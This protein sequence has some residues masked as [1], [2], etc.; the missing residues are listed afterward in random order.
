MSKGMLCGIDLGG[1]KV[2][3]GLFDRGLHP[4]SSLRREIPP[5]IHADDLITLL[6]SLYESLAG[7]VETSVEAI[8]VG[9]PA[10]LTQGAGV[11]PAC[12]N[13]PGV[14][15]VPLASLLEERTGIRV[16][17]ENDANCFALGEYLRGVGKGAHCLVGLTL[18]T[19]IGM[20]AVIAG[21]IHRGWRNSAGEI[22][23]LPMPDGTILEDGLAGSDVVRSANA[24]TAREAAEHAR[25]GAS[26]AVRAWREF[27]ERLRWVIE[28]VGRVLDPDV[29]V[30]GGSISAAC[31]VWG[32]A[33][34]GTPWPVRISTA[35]EDSALLGAAYVAME[36][37]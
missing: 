29:F 36:M 5:G 35:P 30:L 9:V 31:D 12:A 25:G 13:L 17:L 21:E 37:R 19:G 8:G 11:M 34:E 26:R 20:G 27:G 7:N 2:N 16:H 4:V 10:A 15:T 22:W 6:A 23:D 3:A 1:S 14:G 33:L 18:G 32:S 24:V 28:M